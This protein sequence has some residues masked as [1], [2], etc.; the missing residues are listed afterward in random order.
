MKSIIDF[1]KN[2]ISLEELQAFFCLTSYTD[3]VQKVYE[4]I[5]K[6]QISPIINSKLNGK[7]PALYKA[8]R[9]HRVRKD[10]S[11]LE[12]ELKYQLMPMLSNDYYLRNFEA[13]RKDRLFV[14]S[15]NQYLREHKNNLLEA[16]SYNE[17][18]FEIWG[19]EKFLL[20]EGGTRI[21]KNLGLS[22]EELNVYDTTEPLAYYSHH[23]ELPQKIIIL[24]NKD[25]F[26]SMRKSLLA[27]NTSILGVEIGTIIY[28]AGKSIHKSFK[29]FTFCVEP[30]L[31]DSRNEI[32]YFGDLDYE[33]II[34]YETLHRD[35]VEKVNIKPFCN[36]YEAMINKASIE[37]LPKTKKGQ[38]TNIGREFLS[39]FS[40]DMQDRIMEILRQSRYIPQEIL[41]GKD[42]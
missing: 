18:S 31:N 30:Y 6:D 39:Y 17:R 40:Q 28:G 4:L 36:A 25:T 13:Y 3:M 10:N 23:K 26:Y 34:I 27:G 22:P 37:G 14:L 1:T 12:D 11:Q 7:K 41:Q 9:I 29:D 21:L 35:F 20:R 2:K 42:F 8:Y 32:L 5:E 19:R 16:V 15:L 38:N 33:G 24:E